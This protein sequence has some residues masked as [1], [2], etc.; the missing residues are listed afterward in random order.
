[1]KLTATWHSDLTAADD[2][3]PEIRRGTIVPY[4]PVG[5]T[6]AGALTVTAGAITL[7]TDLPRIKLFREHDRSTPVAHL[8]AAQ[9]SDSGL[10]GAFR[11]G[12]TAAALE[13]RAELDER[14]RDG[15]SVELDDVTIDGDRIT[16]A[17]L[18]GV[19]LVAV[20][21]FADARI[22]A[23]E[24]ETHQEE[25][26]PMTT[27]TTTAAAAPIPAPPAA[28]TVATAARTRPVSAAHALADRLI[29]ARFHGGDLEVAATLTAALA[30]ITPG[31]DTAGLGIQALGE[32]VDEVDPPIYDALVTNRPLTGV[33][34]HGWRWTTPP[35]VDDYAGNKAP[36]PTN[37]AALGT[38]ETE[39]KRIAGGHDLD[40]VY[41]DLG[42]SE[43]LVSYWRE[44]TQALLLNLDGKRLQAV[45][46]MS[47]PTAAASVATAIGAGMQAVRRPSYVLISA[48][49]WFAEAAT[50]EENVP[51]L[52]G[53]GF[54]GGNIPSVVISQETSGKVIVGRSSAVDF[55]TQSPPVRLEAVNIAQA[56]V[57]AGIYAYWASLARD[58]AG[59]KAFTVPV[60]TRGTSKAK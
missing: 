16:A 6:S 56:G 28:A 42:S 41:L 11:F 50:A 27:E 30:D 37:P 33:K 7:P 19:G 25:E 13:A 17:T 46:D 60:P 15:L 48:D 20:P 57:D 21:A 4:G 8:E 3:A 54:F 23:T 55:F 24:T 12:S 32:L 35:T 51:A 29:A 5:R 10:S 59:V 26:T 22:A 47:T 53:D 31:D 40:R 58:S 2:D 18:T 45:Q 39:A 14:L 9:D 38:V 36:I 49:L 44:V 34:A 43:V 52:F 1:M